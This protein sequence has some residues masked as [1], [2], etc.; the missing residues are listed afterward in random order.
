MG[1]KE[2]PRDEKKNSIFPMY[3][4]IT[5]EKKREDDRIV[6]SAIEMESAQGEILIKYFFVSLSFSFSLSLFLL[7]ESDYRCIFPLRIWCISSRTMN[8]RRETNVS[9]CVCCVY[10]TVI[11]NNSNKKEKKREKR[12][13]E[14]ERR[15]LRAKLS[16]QNLTAKLNNNSNISLNA[17]NL[18]YALGVYECVFAF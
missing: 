18:F 17:W 1:R 6:P 11:N 5:K 3:F 12:V 10:S 9:Q 14:R 2:Q 15:L 4:S 16:T 13:S 7:F 8:P